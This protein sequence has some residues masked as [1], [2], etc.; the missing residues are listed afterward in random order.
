MNARCESAFMRS[1]RGGSCAMNIM[2]CIASGS[3]GAPSGGVSMNRLTAR[4]PPRSLE[5]VEKSRPTRAM[6]S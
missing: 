6:S 5:N 4:M 2:R 1:W 3:S